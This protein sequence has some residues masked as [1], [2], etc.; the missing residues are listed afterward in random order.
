MWSKKMRW[1]VVAVAACC[2]AGYP[3][4]ATARPPQ[5][6]HWA[7]IN[8]QEPTR[9]GNYVLMGRYVIVHDDEEMALGRPCTTFYRIDGSGRKR[10][11]VAFR[12]IPSLREAV[13][14][15]TL[16]TR[17]RKVGSVAE[18]VDYQFAGETEAHGVPAPLR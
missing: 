2:G 17:T 6:V 15:L 14:R 12:C 11:V 9:V 13:N 5:A 7:V 18:L 1:A 4:P 16:T 10:A 3:A 8:I